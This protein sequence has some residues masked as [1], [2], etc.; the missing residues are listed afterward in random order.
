MV[1]TASHHDGSPGSY[2]S[3]A[4][5]GERFVKHGFVEVTDVILDEGNGHYKID[6]LSRWR[7]LEVDKR[8]Q[9]G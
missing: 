3:S 9:D 1:L 5:Y 4:H 2:H 6:E 8:S 7:S